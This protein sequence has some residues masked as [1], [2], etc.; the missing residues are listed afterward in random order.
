MLT[1]PAILHGDRE[2]LLGFD[3]TEHP[4]AC[5]LG[6]SNPTEMAEAASIVADY[7]Y[8]EINL[9]IGCPSERVQKGA[10]GACLMAEPKLVAQCFEAIRNTTQLPTT[11]KTRIGIDRNDS[12]EFLS[13]FVQQLM[14]AGC[15][16][17]IVHARIAWLKGLSPKENRSVPPLNYERVYQLKSEHPQL[18]IILNGG[19]DT[20]EKLNSPL[21]TLDGVMVGRACYHTPYVFS[22]VDQQL[23]N[24]Q[25][26]ALSRDDVL[27]RY[28]DYCERYLNAN[29]HRSNQVKALSLPLYGLY[30][31]CP[32]GKRF[33]RYLSEHIRHNTT[34][35]NI[36]RQARKSMEYREASSSTMDI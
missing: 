11:I 32:G 31:G 27:E 15:D 30:K 28:L 9:N 1:A 29:K 12:Y 7:G 4:V 20:L 33:R 23:F 3:Q 13:R 8:D 35:L 18:K 2:R 5:Q 36:I 10:F 24:E 6:G 21:E 19:L 16:T 14:Q 17:F 26:A 22:A 25:E 34:D